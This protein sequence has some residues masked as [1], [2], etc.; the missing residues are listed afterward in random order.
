MDPPNVNGMPADVVIEKPIL[1]GCSPSV[2][3]ASHKPVFN[4]KK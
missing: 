4:P 2:V 1:E 3:G